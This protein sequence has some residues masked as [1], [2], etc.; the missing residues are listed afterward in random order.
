VIRRHPLLDAF[1]EEQRR[2]PVN[3]QDN[4]RIYEGL[5]EEARTL[6]AFPRPTLDGIE[7]DIE[8]ARVINTR[9]ATRPDRSN[10]R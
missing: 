5:W 2:R 1:E 6:G 9:R 10:T 8:Y 4:L 7:S 3:Y